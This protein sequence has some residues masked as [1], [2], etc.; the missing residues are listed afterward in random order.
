MRERPENNQRL[1]LLF[2]LLASRTPNPS[3]RKACQTLLQSMQKR[4][5][6]STE[7]ALHLLS[8]GDAVRDETLDPTELAAWTQVTSIVLASDVAIL[9]Y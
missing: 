9:L 7:D 8:I 5:S 3:E 4:F 6:A 1:D 2:T